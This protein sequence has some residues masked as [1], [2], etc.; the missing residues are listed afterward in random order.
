MLVEPDIGIERLGIVLRLDLLSLGR[1]ARRHGDDALDI[2]RVAP[3]EGGEVL[4]D[5]KGRVDGLQRVETAVNVD[6]HG[7]G[8]LAGD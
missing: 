5:L 3:D 1:R 2:V 8:G 4:L 7:E 6:E